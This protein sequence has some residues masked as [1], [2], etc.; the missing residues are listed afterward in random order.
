[1]E[2]TKVEAHEVEAVVSDV[3]QQCV[4]TLTD[5]QLALVGGGQGDI[6]LA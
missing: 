6:H 3:A 4:L 2:M 1:M 5:L